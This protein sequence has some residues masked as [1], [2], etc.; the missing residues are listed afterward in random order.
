MNKK[1]NTKLVNKQ[2]KQGTHIPMLVKIFDMSKGD[3]LEL[4]SGYFSTTLLR[5]LCEMTGRKLYS[6]ETDQF[7]YKKAT[8]SPVDFHKVFLINKRDWNDAEIERPWGMVLIDHSP[9][10]RRWVEIKRLANLAEYI[11]IHDSNLSEVKQYGYEKIWNLFKYRY[12]YTKLNPNTTVV[13]NFHDL[14]SLEL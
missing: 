3:V 8:L 6:Y 7:W 9:D 12:D 13:S 4:G 10:E 11:V 2:V 14:K 1:I 5:W